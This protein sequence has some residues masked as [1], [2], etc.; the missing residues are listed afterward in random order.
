M[1]SPRAMAGSS[2]PAFRSARSSPRA[3]MAS[4]CGPSSIFAAWISCASCSSTRPVWK[5]TNWVRWRSRRG[6]FKE[7]RMSALLRQTNRRLRALLPILS[8]VALVLVGILPLGLP[9]LNSV[10]PLLALMAV[11]YWSIFRADLM[12]MLGAF[13]IG[14]FLDLL[15][16]GPLG[17]NAAT[18]L[19]LHELDRKSVVLG[20]S[21]SVSVDLGG[22]RSLNKKKR[23]STNIHAKD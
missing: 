20:K 6:I 3:T 1:S 4:A 2:P 7:A 11:F 9:H 19:L 10:A 14:L 13:L 17:L 8:S 23:Q 21:V 12:T 16:G 22:R 18:L 5:P 15:S